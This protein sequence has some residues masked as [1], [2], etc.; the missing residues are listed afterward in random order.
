VFYHAG[1]LML[2]FSRNTEVADRQ[3]R[4]IIFL[5]TSFGYVDGTFDNRERNFIRD[6][7]RKLVF[8][9]LRRGKPDTDEAMRA[10]LTNK[11]TQHFLEV[12]DE[13]DHHISELL[14]EVVAEGESKEAF[15]HAKLKLRC[16]EIFRSFDSASQEELIGS[17]N[18]LI[19]A[20]GSVHP[21][22]AKFKDEL[23][24]LLRTDQRRERDSSPPPTGDLK[25]KPSVI[26]VS[27]VIELPPQEA[28]PFFD[29][30][31]HHYSR[32]PETLEKQLGADR[33]L[34][35]QAI[36]A[37]ANQRTLG[38]GSLKGHT[39]AH[40]FDGDAAFLDGHIYVLPVRG[41]RE[42]DITVLGD[43]HG[44]YS[45]LKAAVAQSRFFEK[46]ETW[47]ADP[48]SHPEP[49]LVFLGDYI[50]R[51]LFS[52]NGVLRS[53]LQIFVS[54]PEHVFVLRGNHEYY[55]EYQG[56]VHGGVVPAEAINTLKPLVPMDV[57]RHYMR[58]FEAMPSALIFD[59]IFFVHGGVPRDALTEERYVD[60][61]T[62][63][64]PE[65]RFQMMWSDPAN[66]DF[67]PA[68][69]Q[70]QSARFAFGRLQAAK[71]LDRIGCH[72]LVRG[73][74]KFNEGFKQHWFFDDSH[75]VFTVFSAGGVGNEDLPLDSI[76][77][78]TVPMALTVQRT[79]EKLTFTPWPIDYGHMNQPE[80]N[81][82]MAAPAEIEHR[83]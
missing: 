22:E 38:D 70:A 82:F 4:A 26:E 47:K 49:K 2:Q 31:E 64:E 34:M 24:G 63:N 58:L 65:F 16:F 11:F 8:E 27:A 20:D 17:A 71:F 59:G 15:I 48:A 60:L 76:Y 33:A 69:L 54:A 32:D 80:R 57:F 13:I 3:M 44:C 72:A 28:S 61:S 81:R 46:L 51:G 79:G 19:A 43:L 66:A 9:R 23:V 14:E 74:E 53:V 45:N 75:K 1:F 68:E 37:W 52:L 18:A 73:H 77:R 21:A 67:I 42:Y 6:Y 40:D 29:Q 5:L 35:D 12:F 10:D 36:E 62:L 50:D 56:Q 41:R 39:N 55:I 30:F 25:A 7:I 83:E 78:K